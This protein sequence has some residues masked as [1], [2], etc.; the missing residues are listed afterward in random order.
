MK[1]ERKRHVVWA[2]E[3]TYC[4]RPAVKEDAQLHEYWV[5]TDRASTSWCVICKRAIPI[6]PYGDSPYRP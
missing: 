1:A 3:M 6:D 4:G 5:A 2:N